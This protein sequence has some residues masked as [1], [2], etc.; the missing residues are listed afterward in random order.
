[1]ILL[2]VGERQEKKKKRKK[3]K[4]TSNDYTIVQR[5]MTSAQPRPEQQS[6]T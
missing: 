6:S 1:M 4:P 2:V 3:K 5:L